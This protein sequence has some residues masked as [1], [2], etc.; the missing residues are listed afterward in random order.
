MTMKMRVTRLPTNPETG[1]LV[2]W[3]SCTVFVTRVGPPWLGWP[4]SW[5]NFSQSTASSASTFSI[6]PIFGGRPSPHGPSPSERLPLRRRRPRIPWWA[7]L[8]CSKA[9]GENFEPAF[10]HFIHIATLPNRPRDE[11]PSSHFPTPSISIS[12]CRSS[13]ARGLALALPATLIPPFC[14]A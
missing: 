1:C 13:P 7:H 12:S 14:P 3:S 5:R 4:S 2:R 10:L 9:P 6:C 11:S 8:L